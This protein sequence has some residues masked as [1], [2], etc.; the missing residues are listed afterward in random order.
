[1]IT[2]FIGIALVCAALFPLESASSEFATYKNSQYGFSFSYPRSWAQEPPR[3][4]LGVIKISSE[5]GYGDASCNVVVYRAP[6][7]RNKTT[8]EAVREMSP[9][10]L[11]RELRRGGIND[12]R[13]L[14]SGLTKVFNR[15]AFFAI[16][17]YSIQ[18]MGAIFSVKTFQVIT[19]KSDVVFTFSC[20]AD[21]RSFSTIYPT[22]RVIIGSLFIDP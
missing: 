16:F 22:F 19:T 17:S 8:P 3:S 18:T 7:L 9:S 1:M 4:G 2:R 14:E 20:G 10:V 13:V 12:A 6:D 21:S 15:D 5:G 11:I